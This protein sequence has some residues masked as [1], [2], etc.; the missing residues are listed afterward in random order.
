MLDTVSVGTIFAVLGGALAGWILKSVADFLAWRVRDQ[1]EF[2]RATFGLLKTYKA[3]SDYDRGTTYFRG[4][5]LAL[6]VYEPAREWIEQRMLRVTTEEK[7]ALENA[8]LLVASIK[9]TFALELDRSL[10]RLADTHCGA[11]QRTLVELSRQDI[12]Q[13]LIDE[14]DR[15]VLMAL[16]SLRKAIRVTAWRSGFAAWVKAVAWLW[17]HHGKGEQEFLAGMVQQKTNRDAAEAPGSEA[18]ARNWW[19]RHLSNV[20]STD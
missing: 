18:F 7:D 5:R 14:A 11:L 4:E 20:D 1:R 13:T 12:Y 3:I 15:V 9:P 17:H 2:R 16:I 19:S 6:E 8:V 10:R